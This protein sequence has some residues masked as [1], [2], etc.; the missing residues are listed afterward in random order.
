MCTIFLHVLYVPYKLMFS[1]FWM[2][3]ALAKMRITQIFGHF[4]VPLIYTFRQIIRNSEIFTEFHLQWLIIVHSPM[5]YVLWKWQQRELTG[6][7]MEN[8]TLPIAWSRRSQ[9]VKLDRPAVW[10]R[11]PYRVFDF[12]GCFYAV[13][14]KADD[15][16]PSYYWY[17]VSITMWIKFIWLTIRFLRRGSKCT[18]TNKNSEE[19]I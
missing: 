1:L 16:T 2:N 18:T 4:L 17:N 15:V 7:Q 5:S 10:G 11:R 13:V 19:K 6:N 3:A 14:N 8:Y 9:P 12:P